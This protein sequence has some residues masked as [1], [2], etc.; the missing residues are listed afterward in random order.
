MSSLRD[1]DSDLHS[2]AGK[3]LAD[4]ACYHPFIIGEL[5][6][7]NNAPKNGET[8]TTLSEKLT[9]N[10]IFQKY[11]IQKVIENNSLQEAL[12]WHLPKDL[13]CLVVQYRQP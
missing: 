2:I 1:K 11:V 6:V 12:T 9:A 5:C 4:L 8:S 7:K 13:A 3:A 10:N